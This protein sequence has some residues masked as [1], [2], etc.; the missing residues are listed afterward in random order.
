MPEFLLQGKKFKSRTHLKSE[1]RACVFF[2]S[3]LVYSKQISLV[4]QFVQTGTKAVRCL[5]QEK[6]LRNSSVA[7]DISS[8]AN[9][10]VHTKFLNEVVDKLISSGVI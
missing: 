5:L 1:R 3:L 8:R 9:C 2:Y 10:T 7:T 4:W 6:N